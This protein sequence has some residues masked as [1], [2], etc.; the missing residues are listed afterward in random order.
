MNEHIFSAETSALSGRAA[1]HREMSADNRTFFDA[2]MPCPDWSDMGAS[3]HVIQL[4]DED[5]HLLQAVSRF[6]GAGLEAGEAAVVIATQPHREDIEARLWAHGL[7][8]TTAHAQGQ[9]VPLDAAET[10]SQ[11][12][13]DGWPDARRFVDVVGAVIARAEGRYPRVRVFGEMVALLW[14]EGNGDAALRLEE[15]CNDLV[16]SHAFPLLC[17]YPMRGFSKAEHTE[18]FRTIC[19]TH[20]H[21]IPG[22]SYTTLDSPDARLRTLA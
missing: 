14:A 12:M 4:Y 19:A 20:S 16:K 3:D 22:E 11:V 9:Y 13:I 2:L 7:D 15:L 17:A 5:D 18:K 10:L 1:Q 8:L 6:T 21:V